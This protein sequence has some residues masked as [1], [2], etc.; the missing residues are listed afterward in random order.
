MKRQYIVLFGAFIALGLIIFVSVQQDGIVLA[1]KRQRGSDR[2]RQDLIA[3]EN[4]WLKGEHDAAVL[5][6][7]LAAD[8]VHAVP[9]GDLLDKN[10]HIYYATHYLPPSDQKRRFESLNVR[11]YDDVG[12][13]NGIVVSSDR[14]GKTVDRTVFT[15]VFAF[16]EGRWRAVN[17]QENRIQ[18]IQVPKP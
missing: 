15:D 8:F 10:Q 12:I 5:E 6:G 11:L 4:N 16:R 14:N 13:V 17:A 1:Q 3:L 9:T 18:L 2:D 7:L